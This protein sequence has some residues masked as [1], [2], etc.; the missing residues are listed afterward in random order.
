MT[1]KEYIAY[2]KKIKSKL[3]SYNKLIRYI[4]VHPL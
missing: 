2:E 4:D 1:I 3:K